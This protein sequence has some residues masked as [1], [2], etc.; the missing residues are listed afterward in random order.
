MPGTV[1]ARADDHLVTARP[2]V[3]ERHVQAG[4]Q[5]GRYAARRRGDADAVAGT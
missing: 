5:P 1:Q 3:V 2:Y 4:A